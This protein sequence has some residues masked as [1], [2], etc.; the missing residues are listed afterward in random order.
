MLPDVAPD[1]GVQP[2][3][4]VD[5]PHVRDATV[6]ALYLPAWQLVQFGAPWK[7]TNLPASQFVQTV[8]ATAEYLPAWQRS[9]SVLTPA[10]ALCLPGWQWSQSVLTPAD[11][12]CLPA[13]QF[14]QTVDAMAAEY[15]PATQ[16]SH[17]MLTPVLIPAL[18]LNFPAGHMLQASLL[19]TALNLPASHTSH[20]PKVVTHPATPA[21]LAASGSPSSQTD[22]AP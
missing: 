14:V 1:D 20:A 21:A 9:H 22:G 7:D 4:H 6:S 19:R 12:L 17:S 2:E 5:P 18:D 11:A 3:L 16:S 15:L 8:E 10:E 13:S